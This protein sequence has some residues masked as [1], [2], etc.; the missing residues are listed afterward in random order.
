MKQISGSLLLGI[1][2]IFSIEITAKENKLNFKKE[3]LEIQKHIMAACSPA[4]AVSNLDIN[5]V[6]AKIL[7]ASDMWWDLANAGY[8]VPKN[9]GKH[10]LF[11][12]SIW[13]GGYDAGGQL[14][15]AVQTYRQTGNDFWPGPLDASGLTDNTI[16][17]A[18]DKHYKLNRS[19]VEAYYNWK[20]NGAVGPNP[21]STTAMNT[22]YDWPAIGPDGY[23]LAPFYD[24]NSNSVYE[25]FLG[26][27]P[28]FD[29][30]GTRGCLAKLKGDQNLFWVFNDNGNSHTVSGS[31]SMGL[32]I[33]A[34][35]FSYSTNDELNNTTFYKYKII[36]KS[37]FVYTDTYFGQ[38]IDPDLGNATD[39]YVGCD[40]GR[41]M[42]FCYN[43]AAT[44]AVYGTTPPAIGVDFMEGPFADPFDGLD[45]D[46]DSVI[47]EMNER[48]LMSK[49]VYYNNDNTSYGNP[50]N[51]NEYYNYL[52]GRW[53][54]GTAIT[55]GGNGHSGST[56]C[57]FMFPG[58][59]DPVGWGL[60]GVPSSPNSQSSWSETGPVGDR[61][62]LQSAGP[63]T[64][65]PGAINYVTI[66]VVWAQ[67]TSGGA[68][69][70][71][72]ALKNADDVAQIAF[73]NCFSNVISSIDN[74][75]ISNIT[76]PSIYPNPFSEFTTISFENLKGELFTLEIYDINGNF[77]DKKEGI[78][79]NK[80]I[81]TKN[82]L[83]TGTYIYS[84]TN[85]TNI[86]HT[87]KLIIK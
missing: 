64:C 7:S 78:S 19:D 13:I 50:T 33:Q 85:T 81:I 87:G 67:A 71:I 12:G 65:Q 58:N 20:T 25:P 86:K 28:D 42:G 46:R 1:F 52:K 17:S 48:V 75:I 84:L 53:R 40:V 70:S 24:I 35:A 27:V 9:S 21:V 4:N 31:A 62:F 11:G 61:R 82:S 76:S 73:N 41:N 3:D 44:D 60:G 39:D 80:I 79:D 32:E 45:N 43:G 15:T 63:F 56:P 69:A 54:N 6:R 68:S 14:K 83:K 55:Y 51:Y 59:S 77:I 30:T 38:W 10:S 5:N 49:F 2:L 57:S 29:V 74:H 26:E 22:I 72:Q 36:N 16:C 8:E 18:W 23:P 37:S 66:S 34:Q 47:D